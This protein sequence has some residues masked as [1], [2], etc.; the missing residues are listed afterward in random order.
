MCAYSVNERQH[1]NRATAFK[2]RQN[3][4]TITSNNTSTI[5]LLLLLLLQLLLFLL[6]SLSLPAVA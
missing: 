1:S 6:C 5:L 2:A 4:I 3:S